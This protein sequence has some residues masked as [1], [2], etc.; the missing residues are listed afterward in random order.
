MHI[1]FHI[2]SFAL[3]F[4]YSDTQK[5]IVS[6]LYGITQV[7]G[8]NLGLLMKEVYCTQYPFIDL[9]QLVPNSTK[10]NNEEVAMGL[11]IS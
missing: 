6:T 8:G 4:N 7:K 9:G 10:S 11:H 3:L 2:I 5:H 1:S